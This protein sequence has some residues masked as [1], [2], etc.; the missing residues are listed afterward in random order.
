MPAGGQP[1]RAA[2][3]FAS[4]SLKLAGVPNFFCGSCRKGSGFDVAI[5]SHFGLAI[6]A[7]PRLTRR[8]LLFALRTDPFAEEEVALAR[9]L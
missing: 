8:F 5:T 4:S 9:D 2:P 7:E 6:D 1:F 3:E